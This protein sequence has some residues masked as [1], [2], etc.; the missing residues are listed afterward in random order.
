VDQSKH[1]AANTIEPRLKCVAERVSAPRLPLES[2]PRAHGQIMNRR[3]IM[4]HRSHHR[5]EGARG[6]K[7]VSAE[8]LKKENEAKMRPQL[9]IDFG[10]KNKVPDRQRSESAARGTEG[11]R[12]RPHHHL[13]RG[14]E[15]TAGSVNGQYSTMPPCHC[16]KRGFKTNTDC[17]HHKITARRPE[18]ARYQSQKV[19]VHRHYKPR[20]RARRG[21][22]GENSKNPYFKNA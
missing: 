8:K 4:E 12:A 1:Y 10:L 22:H 7:H 2:L 6:S 20:G 3:S 15:L 21:T 9:R 16:K 19:K 17:I 18:R 5:R 14:C 11:E 13:P